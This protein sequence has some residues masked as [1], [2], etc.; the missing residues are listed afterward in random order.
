MFGIGNKKPVEQVAAPEPVDK[1]LPQTPPEQATA[2]P[3]LPQDGKTVVMHAPSA[4]ESKA[5][6]KTAQNSQYNALKQ[7]FCFSNRYHLALFC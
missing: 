6:K 7:G 3:T 1:T 4:K 2:A 5:N